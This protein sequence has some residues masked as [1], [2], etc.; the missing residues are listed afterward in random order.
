MNIQN[1]QLNVSGNLK[2]NGS[3][4]TEGNVLLRSSEYHGKGSMLYVAYVSAKLWY[5]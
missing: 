5:Y 1:Q 4:K 3:L 2:A